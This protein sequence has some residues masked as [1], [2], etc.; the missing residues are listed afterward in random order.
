MERGWTRWIYEPKSTHFY[1]KVNLKSFKGK[2]NGI[3]PGHDTTASGVSWTLYNVA[4]HPEVQ[5]KIQDEVDEIMRDKDE[6]R[7]E[8]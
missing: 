1:L 5:Q 6:P 3:L 8:W 4:T 2:F 7:I